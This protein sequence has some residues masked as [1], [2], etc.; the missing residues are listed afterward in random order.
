MASRWDRARDSLYPHRRGGPHQSR[1]L[2]GE[3][4]SPSVSA[5]ANRLAYRNPSPPEDSTSG[6]VPAR[7]HNERSYVRGSSSRPVSPPSSPCYQPGKYHDSSVDSS[8][9]S[10]TERPREERRREE[11]PRNHPSGSWRDA[12]PRRRPDCRH[13]SSSSLPTYHLTMVASARV[14]ALSSSINC[15]NRFFLDDKMFVPQRSCPLSS[16]FLVQIHDLASCHVFNLLSVHQRW[17]VV[18][19]FNLCSFCLSNSHGFSKE[20]CPNRLFGYLCPLPCNSEHHFLLHPEPVVRPPFSCSGGEND[21]DCNQPGTVSLWWRCYFEGCHDYSMH[22]PHLCMGF[23]S[24]APSDRWRLVLGNNLCCLCLK[25]GH[26]YF[27]CNELYP[28]QIYAC[29]CRYNF[30]HHILLHTPLEARHVT[31]PEVE[32]T[33]QL[34]SPDDSEISFSKFLFDTSESE[35][36]NDKSCSIE[37]VENVENCC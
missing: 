13:K 28:A 7:L 32:C 35:C 1:G 30:P 25:P 9:R 36:E 20:N 31:L 16:C 8:E 3:A 26:N 21:C 27:C 29:K 14:R 11:R 22:S 2:L 37:N 6:R 24:Y 18:A 23:L 19:Y 17:C 12:D 33:E 34:S 5:T 15:L 10:R 4:P